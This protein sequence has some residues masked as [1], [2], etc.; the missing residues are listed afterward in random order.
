MD[1]EL[2]GNNVA[3]LSTV[4]IPVS[5]NLSTGREKRGY[6]LTAILSGIIS[7]TLAQKTFLPYLGNPS[8]DLTGAIV[9]TFSGGQMIGNLASGYLS[10]A[11]GRKN[12][13]W[14]VSTIALIGTAIQTGCVNVG[15]FLAGRIITGL[16]LGVMF[17][18]ASIYNAEISPPNIRGVIVGMQAMLLAVGFAL[19]N[20]VG[21]LGAY[22]PGDAAWRVPLSLQ[23]LFA[24][25]LI[26]GLFWLPES[27]RWL[28]QHGR[29]EQARLTLQKLHGGST[30]FPDLPEREYNQIKKQIEFERE[31]V[32]NSWWALFTKPSYRYR[33]WLGLG[34]QVSHFATGATA[35]NYYQTI[36]FR[37]I[38][39][40]GHRTL[41]LSVGYGEL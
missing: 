18:V 27:P 39:I 9:S 10:D 20:F 35:I 33:F 13:I 5:T 1:T 23:C 26:I 2:R 3:L 19:A 7:T 24:I 25:I 28:I 31:V 11:L 22:N 40:T 4:M 34:V 37:S 17:N 8:K 12:T 30:E 36:L 21:C 14:A 15:M 16:A 38:G 6:A 29:N 32:I 41:W